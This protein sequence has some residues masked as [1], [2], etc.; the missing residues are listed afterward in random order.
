M[1]RQLCRY[2]VTIIVTALLY[3]SFK[4]D[5][6]NKKKH[7]F[8][9]LLHIDQIK[10]FSQNNKMYVSVTKT[11]DYDITVIYDCQNIYQSEFCT[12]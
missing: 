6:S 1:T 4:S 3:N 9:F 10:H 11:Y 5:F 7:L 2:N 12:L 8:I